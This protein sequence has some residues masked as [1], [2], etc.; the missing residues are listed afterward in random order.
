MNRSASTVEGP[1][2]VRLYLSLDDVVDSGD[3]QIFEVGTKL[4]IPAGGRS[5]IIMTV[6]SLPPLPDGH[7]HFLAQLDRPDGGT[8][9]I[10]GPFPIWIA[11]PHVD[12]QAPSVKLPPAAPKPGRPTSASVIIENRGNVAARGVVNVILRNA[13]DP[14]GPPIATIPVRINLAAGRTRTMR[15]R[16]LLDGGLPGG[17]IM[18]ELSPD[19]GG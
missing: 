13:D 14:N 11:S 19:V 4:R 3:A 12:L 8:D 15:V 2:T 18:A 16:F 9:E 6:T 1:A 7:Y 17:A 5:R 10:P